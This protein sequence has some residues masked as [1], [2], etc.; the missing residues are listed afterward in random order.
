MR[1]RRVL[2]KLSGQAIAGTASFGFDPVALNHI[3]DPNRI[4]VGQVLLVA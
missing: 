4:F 2:V 3:A 1:Y